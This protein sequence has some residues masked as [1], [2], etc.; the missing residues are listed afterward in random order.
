MPSG[1][2]GAEKSVCVKILTVSS[3]YES[4]GG[5]L[6]GVAGALTRALAERGHEMAWAAANLSPAPADLAALPLSAVDPLEKAL[7]LPMPI[8][9]P[10]AVRAL[11]RSVERQDGIIVHDALYAPSL[12]A[13]TAARRHRKPVVLIQHIGRIP[14]RSRTANLAMTL[15]DR[16]VT[17]PVLAGP[18]RVVFIS[19]TV[20]RQFD[21]LRFK[22]EPALLWN[23]VDHSRFRPA[24]NDAERA[25]L[26]DKLG[27]AGPSMLFVGRF[28]EKKGLAV[29]RHLA[30]L[31]PGTTFLLAGWGPIDPA[32]WGLKNVKVLGQVAPDDLAPLYRAADALVLPSVGEGFPLV[33]QEAM[34]SG[35]PV[36]CGLDSAD[37]DP[38]ARPYLRG[39]EVDPADPQGTAERFVRELDTIALGVDHAAAHYAKRTYHWAATAAAIEEM[40]HQN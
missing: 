26:R 13:L 35:L 2:A 4:H 36:L 8:P 10:A 21:T 3:F 15:A 11:W 27:L 29:I 6:E 18:R 12:V 7:G 31:R 28:V 20:R 19:E 34:V 5:G 24:E 32:S 14:F 38:G 9:T 16:F 39:F 40:L 22:H 25:A 33:I 23:G 1:A 17:R 30:A 37:A